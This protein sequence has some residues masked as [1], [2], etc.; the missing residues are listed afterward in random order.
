MTRVMV[1]AIFVVSPS[2]LLRESQEGLDAVGRLVL[3]RVPERPGEN[4]TLLP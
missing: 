3:G 2:A 4:L 1:S